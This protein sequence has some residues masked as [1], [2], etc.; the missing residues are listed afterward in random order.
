MWLLEKSK[1]DLLKEKLKQQSNR[2]EGKTHNDLKFWIAK[3]YIEDG[4]SVDDIEFEYRLARS[5]HN[6]TISDVYISKYDGI[7]IYCE[8]KLDWQWLYKFIERNLP[9]LKEFTSK[10][11]MVFP[12]NIGGLYPH[13]NNKE[14]YDEVRSHDVDVVFSNVKLDN[15]TKIINIQ[16]T[17]DEFD[18]LRSILSHTNCG[19]DEIDIFNSMYKKIMLL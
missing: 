15:I 8:T 12:K 9:I 11:V 1:L 16:L 13:R 7:A 4:C 2:P 19:K 14:F 18:L 6:F 3:K 5:G 10:Q 17:G